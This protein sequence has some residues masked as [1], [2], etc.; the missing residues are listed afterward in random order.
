MRA[1]AKLIAAKC[2]TCG[3]ALPVPPGAHHVQCRY[4]GNAIT[5]EVRKGPPMQPPFGAPGGMPS[6]TLYLDP[7]AVAAAGKGIATAVIVVVALPIL[8][9]VIGGVVA[10]TT[11][12][13]ASPVGFG[14]LRTASYPGSCAVNETIELTGDWQ[15]TGP[16][17]TEAAT[18]CKIRI[19]NAKLKAPRLLQTNGANVEIT[20]ENVTLETT[21]A[22]IVPGINTKVRVTGGGLTSGAEVIGGNGTNLDVTLTNTSLVSRAATALAGGTNLKLD[23]TGSKIQGTRAA[24]ETESNAKLKLKATELVAEGPAVKAKSSCGIDAQGGALT[25]SGDPAVEVE[26]NPSL[27]FEGTKV[28]GRDAAIAATSSVKLRISKK[29]SLVATGGPGVEVSS[30]F[31]LDVTDATI[32]GA[33]SAVKATSSAKVK[34]REGAKLSGQQGGVVAES[35]LDVDATNATIEGGKAAGIQG[36][37]NAKI[38]L[39][40]GVVRGTPALSFTHKPSSFELDGVKVEGDQRLGR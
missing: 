11:V 16:V 33:R 25:S 4:C 12:R 5:V 36:T 22:A 1:V 38:E 18:N 24:I 31:D 26:S 20:L 29:A 40:G 17:I 21:E 13:G 34:L 23:A 3:A 27:A 9:T 19:K 15:G 8:L 28:Q 2:P 30:S 32:Q 14:G 37:S 35:S 6:R 7:E 10:F 39:H